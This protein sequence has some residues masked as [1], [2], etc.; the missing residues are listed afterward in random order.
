LDFSKKA[1]SNT[2]CIRIYRE[3]HM[4]QVA[5]QR[6]LLSLWLL[7][8]SST[9]LTAGAGQE[10]AS[11][12]A[13][14]EKSTLPAAGR[15]KTLLNVAR[16]GRYS[17]MA[18][19]KQGTALQL[20]DRMAGPGGVEG[21][22]GEQDGRL[23][24]FL[25]RGQYL[26]VAHGD[27]RA[28]GTVRLDLRPF[29]ELN[30]PQPPQLIESRLIEGQLRDY[31]QISYWLDIRTRQYVYLEAAGRSLA[32][33]RLWKD[34]SWLMDLNPATQIINPKEGQPLV[35]CRFNVELDPGLYLLTAY[36]GPSQP[37]SEESQAH[38]FYLREGIQRLGMAG[39]RRFE[40]SPFGIDRYLAPGTANYFRLEIP[41]ARPA[42]MQVDWF[43]KENPFEVT[44]AA[45]E[46]SKKSVPPVAELNSQSRNDRDHVVT[47]TADAGQPYVLQQFEIKYVYPF[48]GDRDYWISTIH[49]GYAADSV[50]A[51]AIIAA[52]K[53][54]AQ[55]RTELFRTQTLE[56]GSNEY[57]HRRIN[58]LDP[59]TLFM[60]VKEPG[61]YQLVCQEVEAQYQVEPFMVNRPRDYSPPQP[62]PCG[63]N[64]DL[65]A[66]YYELTITPFKKGIGDLMMR[67]R[68]LLDTIL[69]SVG[70]GKSV[71]VTPSRGSTRFSPVR[72]FQDRSYTLYLN[73]QPEV[74]AGM[75]LRSLPIDLAD[76]LYVVQEPGEAISIP[77]RLKEPGI[78]RAEAE[79]GSLLEIS[80][81]EG[82]WQTSAPIDTAAH[83][84]S[85]RHS[86]K[87]AAQYTLAATPRRLDAQ[88][89]LPTISEEAL[90]A[91][92]KFPVI[93]ET[94]SKFG[95]LEKKQGATY[96]IKA[97]KPALYQL[98]STGLLA[99][100]GNLRSRTNPS[101]VRK[102]QNGVG[103]NFSLQ[104]Y[105]REGDYQMTVE[106]EEE[107]AGHYGLEL[108]RTAIRN[109]G[110]LTSSIPARATLEPGQAIA[111]YFI[112]TNPGSFRVRALG[113]G[114][115]FRCR[116][117]DED[118]WPVL[119]P[120]IQADISRDFSPG[121]YRMVILPEVTTARVVAQIEP[122][123]RLRRYKGHGPHRLRLAEKVNH[124]WME[125]E[126]ND[127][128]TPDQWEFT[129]PAPMEVRIE[130]SDEMQGILLRMEES[131]NEVR[132][133]TVMPG[134]RL[135][136]KLDTGRYRLEVVA[137]RR[138]NRAPY[139][140]AVL[141]TELVAGLSSEVIAPVSIPLSVGKTGLVEINSFGSDDVEARLYDSE[142]KSIAAGDD[143]PDD[144]NFLISRVLTPGRYRLDVS[145]AGRAQAAATISMLT[146]TEEPQ[147]VLSL[148]VR[149]SP[150][151][152][153]AV[154]L[155]PLPAVSSPALLVAAVDSTENVGLAVEELQEGVWRVL[156]S[157]SDKSPRIQIPLG[158]A[159]NT[160]DHRL[161]VWSLDRREMRIG[162][163]VEA[164]VP[165]IATEAQLQSGISMDPSKNPDS[166]AAAYLIKIDHPGL[167]RVDTE[168]AD[169]C[170]SAGFREPCEPAQE[171]L[172]AAWN[173][174]LWVAARTTQAS[175]AIQPVRA[176]R[177]VLSSAASSPLQFPMRDQG[178]IYCDLN[179]SGGNPI[180][181]VAAS[182]GGQPAIQLTER[183]ERRSPSLKNAAI[184]PRESASVL[185]GAREPVAAVWAATPESAGFDVRLHPYY[186]PAVE[187]LP[188][189]SIGDGKLEGMLA[190]GFALG[191]GPKR[192]HLALGNAT[193]AVL[194]KGNEIESVHWQGNDP[195]NASV[196]SVADRLTL[197]HTRSEADRYAVEVIPLRS[198]ELL[199]PLTF[200]APYEHSHLRSGIERLAVLV[201]PEDKNPPAA[202]HV[203]G[204]AERVTFIGNNGRVLHGR[205]FTLPSGGGTLEIAYESGLLLSWLDREGNEAQGLWNA[206]PAKADTITLPA[207]RKLR[208]AA[209]AFNIKTGT[210][211]LLR[212][213]M[214]AP[215][216]S[217][218]RRVSGETETEVHPDHTFVE[219]Y[220]PAGTSQ[221]C[222]R[223]VGGGA[224]S[225]TVEFTGSPVVPISEGLGPE[226]LL[227]PG[228]SRLFSFEV[229][230]EGP[231]GIGVRASSDVVETELLSGSGKSLGK[232]T[233]QKFDLKPGI[234]LLAMRA[235]AQGTPVRA[236]PAVVGIVPP[237]TDPPEAVIRKYLGPEEPA[238]EFTSRQ[239]EA[240]DEYEEYD[241]STDEYDREGT[242]E[243]ME[244]TEE[245]E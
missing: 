240:S 28:A 99:T 11:P 31:E 29:V 214:A 146:P 98:Q 165:Q 241:E 18:A 211:M 168:S 199:P 228:D 197:L 6:I 144:W 120:D 123:P 230:R 83:A 141:P 136:A 65:D 106:T 137:I 26:V 35:L 32:D 149:L 22:A 59:T 177:L 71:P 108:A 12:P 46:I 189:A 135:D 79:D 212:V 200:G 88:T 190:S 133:D 184:A 5:Q 25:E 1:N 205:D 60:H 156:A 33:L 80:I 44:A 90:S 24:A 111:Y 41:E 219:A 76:P 207:A 36:G 93:D 237:G 181:L 15:Q 151:L 45:A 188:L 236:Q 63:A 175:A 62:R 113:E 178:N 110:F 160:A 2:Y 92:P 155:Y 40:V 134:R 74:K 75:I 47:I 124:V 235:P 220:L 105:L 50:D 54:G 221:I 191:S 109:G 51:T 52:W 67:P 39:R 158:G 140:I 195:F 186:F 153:R 202:L 132:I 142:G 180:L 112:I 61:T 206:T 17:I 172:V 116:L 170:W 138:N 164:I 107:S 69:N 85:V 73:R 49:S 82:A 171:K 38:P 232:G 8:L 126:G 185:L 182:Q 100:A 222:L 127:P 173:S 68:G 20:V 48:E 147:A 84:V 122:T 78:L 101:F 125:P 70:W 130:L 10:P 217:M 115:T 215:S 239:Q 225:A 234:Y 245:E 224:L 128:R 9:S 30:A 226:V 208:T 198:E 3:E 129:A 58:L 64:W 157:R 243:D 37:W 16:F 97:D 201:S 102:S 167:F 42:R 218:V 216:V 187:M 91:L 174:E 7:I 145:P 118:G 231:V 193:V 21:V 104:Q 117:E 114:R 162:L 213:R 66:G 94:A 57:W 55:F 244:S 183:D 163:R 176:R 95:D 242:I 192:I 159:D 139:R 13:Q 194:S 119:P 154:M 223:S 4:R 169:H 96:L 87:S 23:D 204:A 53:R 27:K 233:V 131:G 238:P 161:R 103:R 143:R 81:D 43:K 179:A 121:Q 19:S 209:A 14:L 56:I 77:F 148:P 229:K 34:G 150:V 227:A 203:R 89:P 166:P 86:L 152:R 210:P 196:D 72:L